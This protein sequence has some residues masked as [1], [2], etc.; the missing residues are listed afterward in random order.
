M[1]NLP[2]YPG[3]DDSNRPFMETQ[4][5]KPEQSIDLTSLDTVWVRFNHQTDNEATR[6]YVPHNGLV[7]D[8]RTAILN[9]FPEVLRGPTDIQSLKLGE[10]LLNNNRQL[11]RGINFSVPLVII[12]QEGINTRAI[13][14][15]H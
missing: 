11:L 15:K 14:Q 12:R 2:K 13:Q 8:L 10:M 6:V 5:T 9:K 7:D 3:T 1:D 4:E